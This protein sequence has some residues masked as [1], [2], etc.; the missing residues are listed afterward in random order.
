MLCRRNDSEC[1]IHVPKRVAHILIL[2]QAMEC[3]NEV[4]ILS[5]SHNQQKATKLYKNGTFQGAFEGCG[6][7]VSELGTAEGKYFH[8]LMGMCM[9]EFP[10]PLVFMSGNYLCQSEGVIGVRLP[11]TIGSFIHFRADVMSADFPMIIGLGLLRNHEI[12]LK[13]ESNAITRS[14]ADWKLPMTFMKGRVFV[15]WQSTKILL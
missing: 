4:R 12:S 8:E 10:S 5:L 9:K 7:E 13:F 3:K 14:G 1:G 11:L 2:F 15:E 6:E